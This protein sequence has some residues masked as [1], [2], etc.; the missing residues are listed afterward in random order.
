MLSSDAV[1][2][3]FILLDAY[4]I[5]GEKTGTTYVYPGERLTVVEPAIAAARDAERI[6]FEVAT[7]AWKDAPY[8]RPRL[9]VERRDHMVRRDGRKTQSVA[10][11]EILNADTRHFR[12]ME[13]TFALF[14][15][16][17]NLMGANRVLAENVLPGERYVVRSAWP[18]ELIGSVARIE[19]TPRVN[20]FE[21]DAVITP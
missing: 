12:R 8:D 18:H 13:V 20:F 10:E 11:A 17:G 1:R 9:I 15:E 6:E 4:G 3:T 5:I 21:P 7:V 2:Y 19:V 14:D 16:A